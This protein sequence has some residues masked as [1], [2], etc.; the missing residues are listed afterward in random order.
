MCGVGGAIR[1]NVFFSVEFSVS[2]FYLGVVVLWC[3]SAEGWDEVAYP[4]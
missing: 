3:E 1:G 4:R 2:G